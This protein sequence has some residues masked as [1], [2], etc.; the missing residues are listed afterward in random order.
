MAARAVAVAFVGLIASYP[1]FPG[2]IAV[3]LHDP[4]G[5]QVSGRPCAGGGVTRQKCA[6]GRFWILKAEGRF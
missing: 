3:F 2:F 4:Y 5:C 6:S 1:R